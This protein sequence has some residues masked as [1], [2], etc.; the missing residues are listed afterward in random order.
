[1][2]ANKDEAFRC[3]DMGA[4]AFKNGDIEKAE[5]LLNKSMRLFPCDETR[6]VL[7][8]ILA[9]K[10]KR[11][12]SSTTSTPSSAEPRRKAEPE[13]SPQRPFTEQQV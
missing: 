7:A 10:K 6:G 1:M 8:L 13:P 5:R 9:A 11:A 3:R 4:D 2:E 12:Q